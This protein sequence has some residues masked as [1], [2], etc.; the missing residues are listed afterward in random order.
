MT[1]CFFAITSGGFDRD[2]MAYYA[3]EMRNNPA[4]KENTN[5]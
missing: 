5:G 1:H 2:A 3:P 4:T